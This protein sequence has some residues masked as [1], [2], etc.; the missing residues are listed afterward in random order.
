MEEFKDGRNLHR[1]MNLNMEIEI[2][3]VVE[4]NHMNNNLNNKDFSGDVRN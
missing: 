4:Q 1:E 3:T 2:C